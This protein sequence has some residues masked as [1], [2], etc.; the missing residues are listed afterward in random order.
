V[1]AARE[2]TEAGGVDA[3]D[4]RAADERARLLEDRL[5]LATAAVELLGCGAEHR[6]AVVLPGR[7]VLDDAAEALGRALRLARERALGL[8]DPVGLGEERGARG[9]EERRR[10]AVPLADADADVGQ[11]RLEALEP[12]GEVADE[13]LRLLAAAERVDERLLDDAEPLDE[14]AGLLLVGRGRPLDVPVE[15]GEV[16][17][18]LAERALDPAEEPGEVPLLGQLL[19]ERA[20]DDREGP[21]VVAAGHPHALGAH[22]VPSC[23]DET[24]P[25]AGGPAWM[26]GAGAPVRGRCGTTATRPPGCSR[27][28]PCAASRRIR[29]H[30]VRTHAP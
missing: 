23:I 30:H 3:L 2:V 17:A 8:S 14:P 19:L 25:G 5:R 4:E 26:I 6:D 16:R 20:G 22:A 10:R 13:P 18:E 7:G 15:V 28:Q 1:S 24:A 27:P 9:L 11:P 12:V 21:R 29:A